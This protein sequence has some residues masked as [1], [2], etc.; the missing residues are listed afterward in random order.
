MKTANHTDAP[1]AGKLVA[2]T[3]SELMDRVVELEQRIAQGEESLGDGRDYRAAAAELA[4]RGYPMPLE[5]TP[6]SRLHS[7][8]RRESTARNY[9]MQRERRAWL[10][11]STT[12]LQRTIIGG[13]RVVLGPTKMVRGELCIPERVIIVDDEDSEDTASDWALDSAAAT[14]VDRLLSFAHELAALGAD[15][16]AAL[17]VSLAALDRAWRATRPVRSAA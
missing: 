1:S 10:C 12:A 15:V 3:D 7:P 2:A 9:A 17:G 4:L 5:A 14:A 13:W 16:E 11:R 6:A 8:E